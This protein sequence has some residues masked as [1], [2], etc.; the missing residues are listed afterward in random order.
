M[1]CSSRLRNM[2]PF[3]PYDVSQVT[4]HHFAITDPS[5]K[6]SVLMCTHRNEVNA[7]LPVII[8]LQAQ[9]SAGSERLIQSE[10]LMFEQRATQVSP[11]ILQHIS[12]IF[13]GYPVCRP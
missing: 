13:S 11:Y 8:A 5:E 3:I 12:G 7:G 1:D 10:N 9:R 2:L 4:T 6:A